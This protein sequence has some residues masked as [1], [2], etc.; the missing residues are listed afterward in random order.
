MLQIYTLYAM[1]N[2]SLWFQKISAYEKEC[3]KP[4]ITLLQVKLH[5]NELTA[6]QESKFLVAENSMSK[7][8]TKM[9]SDI[10]E[11][12]TLIHLNLDFI[13]KHVFNN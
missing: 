3:F 1:T 13:H 8:Q 5:K 6:Y 4:I 2:P 12:R 9:K 7:F 10:L 11:R